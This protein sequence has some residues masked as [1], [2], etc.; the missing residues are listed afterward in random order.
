MESFGLVEWELSETWSLM[1]YRGQ[2]SKYTKKFD[3][4]L[5]NI[6][7]SGYLETPL[8]TVYG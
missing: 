6:F 8:Y 4:L 7:C 3:N 2:I 5:Q 1:Q